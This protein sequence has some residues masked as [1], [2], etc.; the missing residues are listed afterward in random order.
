MTTD[1][2]PGMKLASYSVDGAPY[3]GAVGAGGMIALSPGF[4]GWPTLREVIAA[5]AL[6]EVAAAAEGR[7]VTH[8]TGSFAWEI[9]IPAPEKILC[10]GVNYANNRDAGQAVVDE[11]E[12]AG[13]RAVLVQAGPAEPVLGAAY[14]P[15]PVS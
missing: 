5:G 11:I 9:P 7:A 14:C 10:V 13:G 3:W 12:K 8:A 6:G 15:G 4:P 2:A 1:K